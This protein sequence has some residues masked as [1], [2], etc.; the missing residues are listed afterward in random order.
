MF[1]QFIRECIYLK[2]VTPKTVKFYQN[3][4]R[5]WAAS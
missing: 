3:L 4:E 5:H 1:D 2:N